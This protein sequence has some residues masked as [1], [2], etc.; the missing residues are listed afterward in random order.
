MNALLCLTIFSKLLIPMNLTQTN[1]LKAYGIAYHAL[2]R[3]QKVEWL[4]N[5]EGGSFLME[6]SKKNVE[7]CLLAGVKAQEIDAGT[8]AAIRQTIEE[9]NMNAVVLEKPPRIAVYV[10]P[11]ADP[12]DDA[13]RLALDYAK[14]PYDMLWDPEVLAGK[15]KEYDWVHLH[16]E[17][18][19]GQFGKF[20]SSYYTEEWYQEQVRMNEEIARR[21]KFGSVRELKLA[22]AQEIRRY[23]LSGG[24]LFAMCSATD[25]YD[26]AL[27]A[28]ATDIVDRIFDATPVDPDW[29]TKLDF[30]PTFAFENFTP[31]T[32][33]YIYEHS[34]I[35]V[36]LQAF[37]RGEE[38]VFSLFDFSAKFDPVPSMLV[39]NHVA[40][41]K[42]FLGQN[43]GFN[44]QFLKRD[45]LI[46]GEVKGSEEVKYIHGNRGDGTFTFFG[47]HDPE[48]Y[49][50]R[51]GDPATMLELYPSSPGYRLI[52]NNVLF[53]AA[54]KK[55]LKT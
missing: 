26:M 44:R 25:T 31:V 1:H 33:P 41:V 35:D 4:L 47:G 55:P 22:V 34:D 11:T 50:H 42:E 8:E 23:V 36:S 2:E 40:Y 20:Y 53:P 48:D 43:T 30:N 18:F 6:S 10:P 29:N 28:A 49:Q 38:T 52:L 7:E 32:D 19:T 24:F 27:A 45:V 9:S 13:V 37:D 17:D 15:L 21:L 3:G 16:H 5:Y 14:I 51:V 46:L 39:Q 12:W 54:E